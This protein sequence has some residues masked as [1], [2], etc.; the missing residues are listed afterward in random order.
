MSDNDNIELVAR[1]FTYIYNI[2]VDS[3]KR[4]S[5]NTYLKALKKAK[6]YDEYLIA[7]K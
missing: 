2:K 3:I 6:F 5:Q 1:E 7:L 4:I